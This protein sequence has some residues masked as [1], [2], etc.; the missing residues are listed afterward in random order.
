MLLRPYGKLC[1]IVR[2]DLRRLH[3]WMHIYMQVPSLIFSEFMCEVS[4]P[5]N[6]SLVLFALLY[7]F[8]YHTYHRSMDPP[9]C[10]YNK[11]FAWYL[12]IKNWLHFYLKLML[13]SRFKTYYIS[14]YV[15]GCHEKAGMSVM[16]LEYQSTNLIL[17]LSWYDVQSRTISW[18][19]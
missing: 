13:A 12:C 11:Y 8:M 7:V 14:L 18:I 5:L 16:I 1:V 2:D 9:T 4:E 10:R 17:I 19:I 3:W 6:I 15:P